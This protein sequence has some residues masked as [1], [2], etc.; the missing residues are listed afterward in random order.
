MFWGI[1]LYK[2]KTKTQIG[3]SHTQYTSI[4]FDILHHFFYYEHIFKI[5]LIYK[6]MYIYIGE[7]IFNDRSYF[8]NKAN[9]AIKG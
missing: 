8:Y 7:S 2:Q 3:G 9:Q 4:N 6:Y 5:P 1:K